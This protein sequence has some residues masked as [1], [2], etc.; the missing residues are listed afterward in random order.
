MD[1]YVCGT[2]KKV[3]ASFE[4]SLTEGGTSKTFNEKITYFFQKGYM[5]G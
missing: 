5:R 3:Y 4:I 1:S 2:G